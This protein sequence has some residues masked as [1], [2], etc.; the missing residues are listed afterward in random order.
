M[1]H[2]LKE[3]GKISDFTDEYFAALLSYADLKNVVSWDEKLSARYLKVYRLFGLILFYCVS[4]GSNPLR[5]VRTFKNLLRNKHESR[6]EMTLSIYL[7]RFRLFEKKRN[8]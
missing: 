4:Y 7:K 3:K 6:M 8:I 5:F 1:Y 2:E